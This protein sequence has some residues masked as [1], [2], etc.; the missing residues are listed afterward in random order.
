MFT[1]KR[2]KDLT[3]ILTELKK[4]KSDNEKNSLTKQQTQLSIKE[5]KL[6]VEI[7]QLEELISEIRKLRE[8]ISEFVKIV[9]SRLEEAEEQESSQENIIVEEGSE[10]EENR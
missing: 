3:E 8:D 4:S 9:K 1:Q 6:V 2:K 5:I 10:T 7:S